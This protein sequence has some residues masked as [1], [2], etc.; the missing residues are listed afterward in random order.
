MIID[1]LKEF[2]AKFTESHLNNDD[3]KKENSNLEE[4]CVDV[5][6][7]SYIDS[8][9]DEPLLGDIEWEEEI[10][11]EKDNEDY[12]LIPI[13]PLGG[14]PALEPDMGIEDV[15]GPCI[16]DDDID[17]PTPCVYGPPSWYDDLGNLDP[18]NPDAKGFIDEIEA[19]GKRNR[20]R[21]E[22]REQRQKEIQD[23]M[24]NK[25]HPMVYGPKPR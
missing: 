25:P 19:I 24:V 23:S 18:S 7:E 22:L 15:Y 9:E 16:P 6:P 2:I 3:C 5:D 10:K 12:P 8:K 17:E 14:I 11:T 20:W 21:A 13:E 4:L 1:N